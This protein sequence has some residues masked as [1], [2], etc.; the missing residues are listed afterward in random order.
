[1]NYFPPNPKEFEPAAA[2]APLNPPPPNGPP[3]PLLQ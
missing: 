2:L 3:N 1:M